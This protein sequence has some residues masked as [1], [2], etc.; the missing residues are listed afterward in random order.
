MGGDEGGVG[1]GEGVCGVEKG[2]WVGWRGCVCRGA[3]GGDEEQND[4]EVPHAG[5]CW[6]VKFTGR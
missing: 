5:G 3:K 2:G 4:R 6:E 1:F